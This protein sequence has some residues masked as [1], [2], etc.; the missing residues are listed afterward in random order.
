[1]S[2]L[3]ILPIALPLGLGAWLFARSAM[4]LRKQRRLGLIGALG[5]FAAAV[6]LLA[7][8][9]QG[10]IA[11]TLIGDWP[12]PYGIVLA[13]DR[14]SALMLTLTSALALAAIAHLF[15]SP[16]AADR[17]GRHFH[18]LFQLQLFGLAGAFLTADLF[19]LFVFFEVLLM[20]SYGL[21]V[22]GGGA[23]RSRAALHYVVLNM[24]GSSLFL[25]GVASLY[26]L[27]GTLNLAE[28]SERLRALQPAQAPLADFTPGN[29]PIF[30]R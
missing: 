13:A 21:L 6:G 1:M 16:D 24:V 11:A 9:A 15:L 8:S 5:Q 30:R 23:A 19:N 20:A 27:S 10:P 22:Q 26:A 28:L 2:L 14:L 17:R 25:M 7:L 3:L 29:W 18:A 12:V 4:P